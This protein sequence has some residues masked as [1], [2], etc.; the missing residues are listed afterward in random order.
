MKGPQVRY[1]QE[2]AFRMK[3]PTIIKQTVD[4]TKVNGATDIENRGQQWGAE[5][6]SY[7]QKAKPG[8]KITLSI[9]V[10]MPDGTKRNISSTFRITR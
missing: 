4:I 3:T 7:I 6:M 1:G 10:N 2:F 5:V 8:C 9:D